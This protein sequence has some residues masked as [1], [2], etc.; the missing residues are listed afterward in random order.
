MEA[1]ALAKITEQVFVQKSIKVMHNINQSI[2]I[3]IKDILTKV[4][5]TYR[6]GYKSSKKC[7]VS[8]PAHI[9]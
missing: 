3:S 1:I 6:N 9:V 2:F 5:L 7:L 4:M 8:T